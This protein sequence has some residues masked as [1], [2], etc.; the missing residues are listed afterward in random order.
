MREVDG[1]ATAGARLPLCDFV[2]ARSLPTAAAA[3]RSACRST[4]GRVRM[5]ATHSHS[6][7]VDRYAATC[8]SLLAFSCGW[9][10][11]LQRDW[12]SRADLRGCCPTASS[13][14]G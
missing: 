10:E 5:H 9:S 13:A 3:W 7:S 14:C 11:C 6:L 2:H 12:D 4:P 1:A 8:S